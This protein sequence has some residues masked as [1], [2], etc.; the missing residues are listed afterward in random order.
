MIKEEE[1]PRPSVRLSTSGALAKVAAARKTDPAKLSKLVRGELDW[2]VM[3]CL[4]KNCTRRYESASSLARE[5]ERYLEDKP[6]EVGPPSAW[7]R[8]SKLARR[9][10]A[11]L[12]TAAVVAAALIL[13][14]GVSIWQAIR[15]SEAQRVARLNEKDAL[16]RKR[17]ADDAK[18][19]AVRMSYISDMN[20]AWRAIEENNLG[21]A[22]EL[23]DRHRPKSGGIDQRGFEWHYLHRLLHPAHFATQWVVENA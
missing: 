7:Y 1:P 23:L 14:T 11:A 22:R 8:F 15:A 18:E 4:E 6:V 16:D 19:Q 10:K 12:T 2:V 20:L 3:K 21:F 17:E 9:N 5:V 13:G